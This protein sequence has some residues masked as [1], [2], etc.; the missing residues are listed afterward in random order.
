VVVTIDST[1]TVTSATVTGSASEVG[2]FKGCGLS[3]NP[4]GGIGAWLLCAGVLRLHLTTAIASIRTIP[5][6][7]EVGHQLFI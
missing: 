7:I 2:S 1:S 5:N 4:F 3:G 6:S